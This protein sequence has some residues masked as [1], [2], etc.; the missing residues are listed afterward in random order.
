ML[1]T[2][3]ISDSQSESWFA[4]AGILQVWL[5]TVKAE[6]ALAGHLCKSC[7]AV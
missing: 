7:P 2:G 4:N 3:I 5:F 6:L 1:K